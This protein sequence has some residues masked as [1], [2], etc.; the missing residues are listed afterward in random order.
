M[1]SCSV[2]VTWRAA[3]LAGDQPSLLVPAVAVGVVGRLAE[4]RQRL[5]GRVPAQHPV[6][7]DVAPDQRPVV[8]EPD[9]ALGPAAPGGQP[10]QLGQGQHIGPEALVEDAHRRV[11][12]PHRRLPFGHQVPP[13][14][15]AR[16]RGV[17]TVPVLLTVT[18]VQDPMVPDRLDHPLGAHRYLA[19]PA[20]A[21]GR[22]AS[23]TRSTRPVRPE[24]ARSGHR[25]RAEYGIASAGFA[26]LDALCLPVSSSRAVESS[27]R[28]AAAVGWADD[29]SI[30]GAAIKPNEAHSAIT[31][32]T[33]RCLAIATSGGRLATLP[34][35][36]SARGSNEWL[37]QNLR[38]GL[39][40][41]Q[42]RRLHLP[43]RC[44]RCP[45]FTC[46]M[47]TLCAVSSSP[48]STSQG[49]ISFSVSPV[50]S[51]ISRH[52]WFTVTSFRGSG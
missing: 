39:A 18:G 32:S 19:A 40:A 38:A 47:S 13:V 48:R 2:R 46:G 33:E 21:Q 1:P 36:I 10:L 41:A 25:G 23:R 27:R 12:H 29:R 11:G 51:L 4:H 8:A 15:S 30:T 5:V 31:R 3:V 7:G 42:V 35:A 37:L 43:P 28:C 44:V 6:V 49:P 16:A 14:I 45:Q 22:T 34:A 24:L 26:W 52:A 17:S 20:P 9:R 50:A